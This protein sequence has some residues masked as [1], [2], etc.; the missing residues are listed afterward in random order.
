VEF[1]YP[2]GGKGPD[3]H[4]HREHS[5]GFYVLEGE[6]TIEVADQT[7]R[8]GPGWFVMAP[9]GVVHTFR[10]DSSAE[11]RFLNMHVPSMGFHEYLEGRLDDFDQLDPPADGGR[12]AGDAVIRPA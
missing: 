4:I 7:L 12:P 1:H 5:D 2:A 10:N 3:R 11:A 8:A 6:L 9:P